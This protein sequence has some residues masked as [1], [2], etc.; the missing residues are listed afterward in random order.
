MA[1]P[2]KMYLLDAGSEECSAQVSIQIGKEGSREGAQGQ[3][4]EMYLLEVRGLGCVR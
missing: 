1:R 4:R 3:A 2:G